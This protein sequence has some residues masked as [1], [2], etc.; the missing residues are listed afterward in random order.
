V[1]DFSNVIAQNLGVFV[2][3]LAVVAVLA[4]LAAAIAIWRLR[5]IT[6][7]FAWVAGDG[8]GSPDTLGALLKVVQSNQT[9]IGEIRS[10]LDRVVEDGRSH[11]K[12]AGLVRYD[13]FEGIAGKQS[14]SLCLLDDNRDGVMVSSLVGH[15]FSRSYAV[16]IKGG[17]PSRRLGDE[18]AVALKEAMAD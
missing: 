5:S 6:R 16:D 1:E 13:A 4:L 3:A 15:G 18:E 2:V 12:H 10:T 11:F 17:Q 9:S 8:A 14:Y 7:R